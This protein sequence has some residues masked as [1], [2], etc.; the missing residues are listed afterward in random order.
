VGEGSSK[1]ID[2]EKDSFPLDLERSEV[3][4]AVRVVG[5]AEVII[6]SDCL[7]DPVE[8]FPAKSGDPGGDDGATAD[9]MLPPRFW[10][11]SRA[12]S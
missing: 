12:P 7:N 2:L 10:P 5:V 4:F 11:A 3:M 9:Q 8:R 1:I 6:P